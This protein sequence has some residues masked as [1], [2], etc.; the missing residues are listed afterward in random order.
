M[1]DCSASLSPQASNIELPIG[2]GEL[3]LIVDDEAAI[4][5]ITQAA[6]EKHNYKLL[7]SSDGIEALALYAQHQDEISLVLTDMMMPLMDGSTTIHT[8]Q[9]LN[10]QLKIIAVS[11][12]ASNEQVVSSSGVGVKAFLS[13]PY[14]ARELLSTING[15]L[16]AP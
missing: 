16:S 10:P 12:L 15:V 3:I 8:L 4:C 9:K 1:V 2:H 5:E 14:T 11:G 7:T 13:K 6:L